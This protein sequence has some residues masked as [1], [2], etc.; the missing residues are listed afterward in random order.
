MIQATMEAFRAK[1][2]YKKETGQ[3]AAHTSITSVIRLKKIGV[4]RIES[5][6]SCADT[7]RRYETADAVSP[8]A[9]ETTV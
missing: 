2:L 9:L 8:E 3:H 6:A 5:L 4:Q 1:G 7:Q